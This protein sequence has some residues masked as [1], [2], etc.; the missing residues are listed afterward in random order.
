M[1]FVTFQYSVQYIQPVQRHTSDSEIKQKL[2]M[3]TEDWILKADTDS[4]ALYL[5]FSGCSR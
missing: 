2:L 4:D 3:Q 1:D 5:L